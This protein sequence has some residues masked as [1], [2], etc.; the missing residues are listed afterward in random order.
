MG[1]PITGGREFEGADNPNTPGVVIVSSYLAQHFFPNQNPVGR[2]IEMGF[3]SGVQLE[4]VGVAADTTQ[5]TLKSEARPGMYIPYRQVSTGLPTILMLRGNIDA[6]AMAAAVR[7]QLRELDPQL[8]VYDIK[9]MDQVLYSAM[10]RPRFMTVLL[11][12][13]AVLAVLL[14]AVGIYGVMS[15]AVAQGTR[16][17]GIRIA[18]GAQSTDILKLVVGQG[19][20]LVSIG[21]AIG[22]IAAFVLTRFMTS[23]LFGV[24]P[25]DPLTFVI[26]A[27]VL[28]LV[29][30]IACYLPARRGTK[31]NPIVALRYE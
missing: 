30:G 5:D 17:I 19:F 8:P 22:I 2:K 28:L 18:I 12:V 4:I 3:R 1:I 13:F 15:Y 26:G 10:A 29:A 31:V 25:S 16:E 24:I 7:Q 11:G 21:V 6:A 9:T 27:G 14:A 20:I 23:A